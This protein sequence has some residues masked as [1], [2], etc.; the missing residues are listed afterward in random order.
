[1]ER[2]FIPFN[3]CSWK[4]QKITKGSGLVLVFYFFFSST[5]KI[6]INV[7]K[8]FIDRQNI[9]ELTLLLVPMATTLSCKC[10]W[11]ISYFNHSN[12]NSKYH[13][14]I[15]SILIR[16]ILLVRIYG[17]KLTDSGKDKCFWFPHHWLWNY[18]WVFS[19]SK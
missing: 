12:Y 1:M 5:F 4:L 14:K 8:G 16:H 3:Q 2:L 15:I 19:D 17:C 7:Y 11:N 10:T 18:S 9:H 6:S 13:N